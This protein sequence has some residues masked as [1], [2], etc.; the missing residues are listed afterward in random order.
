MILQYYKKYFYLSQIGY[1]CIIYMCNI[2]RV[3]CRFKILFILFNIFI[4]YLIINFLFEHIK[5]ENAS[6]IFAIISNFASIR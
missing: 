6:K 3:E 5:Y 1:I 2:T 4:F